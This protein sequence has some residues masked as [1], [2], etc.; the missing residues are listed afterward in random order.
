LTTKTISSIINTSG[1]GVRPT[2]NIP[3]TL[4]RSIKWLITAQKHMGT[5]LD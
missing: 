1:L 2:I 5:T 4:Q 3:H